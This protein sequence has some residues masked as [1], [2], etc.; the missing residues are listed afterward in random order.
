MSVASLCRRLVVTVGAGESLRAAAELM[1][2]NHV[3]AL[4]VLSAAEPP[5]VCGLVTDR[6]IALEVLARNLAPT[7][8]TVGELKMGEP[9][10]VPGSA[11][12]MEAVQAMEAAGVR[13][14]L[15]TDEKNR[16][17]GLVS[18]DDVI[19]AIAAQLSCLARAI[20]VGVAQEA[21]RS[22]PFT[23]ITGAAQAWA[24]YQPER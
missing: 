24:P 8:M 12:L 5:M 7:G 11:S 17:T 14:L 1:R 10:T 16:V 19:E 15:V 2:R 6:D 20:R 23:S 3:G 22:A 13:R 18:V 4:V 9:V 21:Q